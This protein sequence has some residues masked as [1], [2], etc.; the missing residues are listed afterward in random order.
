MNVKIEKMN[1]PDN[2]LDCPFISSKVDGNIR[3]FC[4]AYSNHA[5]EIL[6]D[7]NALNTSFPS[8]CSIRE[9]K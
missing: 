1:K 6:L 5:R 3:Y 7:F 4:H 8:W 2:C 9:E